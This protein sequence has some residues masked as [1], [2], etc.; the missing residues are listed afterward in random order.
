MR[1]A[2]GRRAKFSS[3]ANSYERTPHLAQSRRLG[4]KDLT[5]RRVSLVVSNPLGVEERTAMTPHIASPSVSMRS[6]ECVKE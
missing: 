5:P 3:S 2:A 6:M 4:T 1:S